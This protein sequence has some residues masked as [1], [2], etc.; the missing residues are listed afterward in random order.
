M[1]IINPTDT[2]VDRG[3]ATWDATRSRPVL[4]PGVKLQRNP[5]LPSGATFWGYADPDVWWLFTAL[6][7]ELEHARGAPFREYEP[8]KLRTQEHWQ[9]WS[10]EYRPIRGAEYAATHGDPGSW[11]IHSYG[12]AFDVESGENPLGAGGRGT[13][14]AGTRDR[15]H[16][17]GFRWGAAVA[18]GGDYAGRPDRQHFEFMGTPAQAAAL[19][20]Q[21]ALP[22]KDLTI[23][24]SATQTYLNERFAAIDAQLKKL[25]RAI[26]ITWSGDSPG[27]GNDDH[28]THPDN[29]AQIRADIAA[30]AATVNDL[31]A[32]V[33]TNR[34]QATQ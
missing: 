6:A 27:T 5:T 30:V 12:I 32:L 8:G 16:K 19:V 3:W 1:V 2:A 9:C 13:L 23:V 20:R 31:A 24:D 10:G 33:P 21:F 17:Y 15:A 28:D 7:W 34:G 26:G 29:L 14:P 18:A 11:S 25:S 22:G 4:R